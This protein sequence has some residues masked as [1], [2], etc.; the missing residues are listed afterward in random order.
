MR[1]SLKWFGVD[2]VVKTMQAE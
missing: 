2:S 1:E